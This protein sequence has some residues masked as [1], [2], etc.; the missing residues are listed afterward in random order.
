MNGRDVCPFCRFFDP[1]WFLHHAG[2]PLARPRGF[3][4]VGLVAAL[5]RAEGV[6]FLRARRSA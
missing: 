6:R 1:S 3:V 4:L 2:C 5:M